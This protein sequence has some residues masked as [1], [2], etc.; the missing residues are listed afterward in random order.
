ME[1]EA[2][3]AGIDVGYAPP[4]DLVVKR[5]R[6][7]DPQR[8]GERREI[9]APLIRQRRRALLSRGFF[10]ARAFS[11]G[12]HGPPHHLRRI[13][14]GWLALTGISASAGGEGGAKS[15]A[16]LQESAPRRLR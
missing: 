13:C 8:F 4:T 15:K 6:R 5:R 2:V 16:T 7:D 12:H 11:V 1:Q 3:L 9:S 14:G 10:E